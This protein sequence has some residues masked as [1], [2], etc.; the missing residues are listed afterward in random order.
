MKF[1]YQSRNSRR[2]MILIVKISLDISIWISKS[3][4][5]GEVR[6][7]NQLKI[8]FRQDGKGFHSIFW[9]KNISR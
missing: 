6:S 2:D 3:D 5:L 9:P 8:G 4:I 7:E 1:L